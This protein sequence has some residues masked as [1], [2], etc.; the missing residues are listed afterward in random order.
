MAVTKRALRSWR[1]TLL[2]VALVP[3]VLWV[4]S[5]WLIRSLLVCDETTPSWGSHIALFWGPDFEHVVQLYRENPRR[6]V[7]LFEKNPARPMQLKVLP[8]FH[9]FMEKKLAEKEVPEE[10]VELMI[11]RGLAEEYLLFPLG[12]LAPEAEVIVCCERLASRR[13]RRHFDRCLTD[14]AEHVRIFAI[15]TTGVT[16]FNWWHQPGGVALVVRELLA[17]LFESGTI[18]P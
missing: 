16:E 4:V 14:N 8:P 15:T 18:P 11:H 3:I 17:R 13:W 1:V 7:L 12:E 6:R 2:L 9:Q 10:A 5:L